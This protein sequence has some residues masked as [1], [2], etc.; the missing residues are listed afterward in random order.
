MY[1]EECIGFTMIYFF[2][3]NTIKS[4]WKVCCEI[5]SH[6]LFPIANRIYLIFR[7]VIGRFS[8]KCLKIR[9]KSMHIL[10]ARSRNVNIH[11]NS[12][13]HTIIYQRRYG[14]K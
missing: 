7:Q 6:R 8:Q 3:G 13:K 2:D 14:G 9:K 1:S 5:Y 12:I 4:Y 10:L 11:V